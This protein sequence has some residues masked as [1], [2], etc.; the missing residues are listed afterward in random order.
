MMNTSHDTTA[1][2][3]RAQVA[4]LRADIAKLSATA[5][6]GVGDGIDSAGRRMARTG[7]EAKASVVDAVA[8]N[9]LIAVGL[10]AGV[11]YL[12]GMLMRR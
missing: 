3:L 9:P 1:D 8:A 7:R 2:D 6:E 10:A 12:L 4:T 5:A 11:G